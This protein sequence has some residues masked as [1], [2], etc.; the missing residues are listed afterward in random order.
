M[1]AEINRLR[2]S[3]DSIVFAYKLASMLV[4]K[5]LFT[6]RNICRIVCPSRP[7]TKSKKD[8]A[9]A[10]K[11]YAVDELMSMVIPYRFRGISQSQKNIAITSFL[12]LEDNDKV[13]VVVPN[14]YG[15]G[16]YACE[17]EDAHRDGDEFDMFASTKYTNWVMDEINRFE[18]GIAESEV[19]SVYR[20]LE[21]YYE[22]FT[23]RVEIKQLDSPIFTP[24]CTR[25]I[26]CTED[27]STSCEDELCSD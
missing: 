5:S 22:A 25:I 12:K 3:E 24:W 15:T 1:C 19:P 16:I 27:S 4:C 26:V 23:P 9:K 13:I 21:E 14:I 8:A 7:S 10:A 20:N 18:P 2:K 17:L 6:T 11:I